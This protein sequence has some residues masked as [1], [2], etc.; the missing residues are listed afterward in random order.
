MK[1]TSLNQEPSTPMTMEG[2][3]GVVKQLP[4]GVADGA[5]NFSFRVFTLEP[6]GHTPYHIHEAEHLNYVCGMVESGREEG[7]DVVTGGERLD[8]G[9]GYYIAPTVLGNAS[10]DMAVVQDEIF[11]PVLTAMRIKDPNEIPNQANDS[12]YGLAASIWTRDIG[13][14][15]RLAAAMEA[16]LVWINCHAIP[17]LAVPFGGYKQSGWG[18]EN[19]LEGLLEYTELKSVMA[20]L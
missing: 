1:I 3:A 13:K 8:L 15:H 20:M 9:G 5:P 4:L 6:G 18:R 16:G 14:A 17:D 2:A 10:H 7:V 12:R 19:G 11:G